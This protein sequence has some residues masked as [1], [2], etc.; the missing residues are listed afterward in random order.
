MKK[1]KHSTSKSKAIGTKGRATLVDVSQR[2]VDSDAAK[3]ID[4]SVRE[5]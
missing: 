5:D 4:T 2:I 3:G 1:F